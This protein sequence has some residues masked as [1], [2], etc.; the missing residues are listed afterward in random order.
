[1]RKTHR[2]WYYP[3]KN[4]GVITGTRAEYGLLSV[5]IGKIARSKNLKLH[6]YVTGMHLLKEYGHTVDEILEKHYPFMKT[7][8]MYEES[9]TSSNPAYIGDAISRGIKEFTDSF[10]KDK[11][12]IVLVTGDRVEM[13]A[14]AIAAAALD[15]PIVHIHGGDISE[16]AQIDEQIRHALTKFAHIHFAATDKSKQRILQMG[17][18]SWRVYNVGSPSIDAIVEMKLYSKETLISNLGLNNSMK[19]AD[20]YVICIQHPTIAERERSGEFMREIISILKKINNHVILIYPNNDP[21][22]DLIV[23]EINQLSATKHPL[24]HI[25]Q[26]ID[27]KTYLSA[28]KHARLMIGN[29][30]S[31]IIESALFH[32]PVVNIGIRNKNRESSENV[33]HVDNGFTNIWNGILKVTSKSFE[34]VCE[35]TIN[36]YGDGHA[37]DQIVRIL[38][39]LELGFKLINKK[40]VPC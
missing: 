20:D 11:L 8:P 6:L 12:D 26:N 33:I 17:E 7:I 22:S 34:D 36:V 28:L 1:M 10:I 39:D 19:T 3:M 32:L 21:G 9:S 35:K 14:A 37:S 30:S 2:S 38:E 15:L 25:Y 27:R 16:N 5:L 13:L 4:V 31:G 29:S 23:N 40:F 18:E 24:F